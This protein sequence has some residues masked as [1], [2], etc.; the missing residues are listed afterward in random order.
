MK[1]DRQVAAEWGCIVSGT[2]AVGTAAVWALGIEPG[3]VTV[4]WF[5]VFSVIA[6]LICAVLF[7]LGKR[8]PT[9][10][11]KKT[12]ADGKSFFAL[13]VVATQPLNGMYDGRIFLSNHDGAGRTA[14]RVQLE[15]CHSP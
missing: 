6:A 11:P 15:S 12:V 10:R 14:R 3:R 1:L 5:P 13:Q 7:Y 8:V 9:V 2:V 4:S